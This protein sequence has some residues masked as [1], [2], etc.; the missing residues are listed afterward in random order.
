MHSCTV[1]LEHIMDVGVDFLIF[2]LL[3]HVFMSA[4]LLDCKRPATNLMRN[5][6]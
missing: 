2:T 5:P 4:A 6:T 3:L 1:R